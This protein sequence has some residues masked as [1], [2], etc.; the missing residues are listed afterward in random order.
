[1]S[2]IQG[3]DN[4]VG[5]QFFITTKAAPH[6]NKKYTIFGEVVD[7]KNIVDLIS[8]APRDAMMKPLKAIKLNEIIIEK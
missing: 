3:N 4:S 6:L 8:R 2:K 1:M 7:G 5:S